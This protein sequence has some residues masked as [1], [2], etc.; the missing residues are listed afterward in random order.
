MCSNLGKFLLLLLLT[1]GG[2]LEFFPT[3]G[4]L[5]FFSTADMLDFFFQLEVS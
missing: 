2:K 1:T 4:K 5:Q 3:G